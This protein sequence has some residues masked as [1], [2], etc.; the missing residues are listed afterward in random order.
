MYKN[1]DQVSSHMPPAEDLA[2]NPGMSPDWELNLRPFGLQ[3][4]AQPTEP[5]CQ[6]SP[7]LFNDRNAITLYGFVLIILSAFPLKFHPYPS[8]ISWTGDSEPSP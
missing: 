8:C 6:G 1:I 3:E 2:R 5:H 7:A 4:N